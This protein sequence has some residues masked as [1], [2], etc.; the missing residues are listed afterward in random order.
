MNGQVASVPTHRLRGSLPKRRLVTAGLAVIFLLLLC[1]LL[2]LLSYI[3]FALNYPF[4]L[5][6]GEG[7]V[8]QQARNIW[9]GEGYGPLQIFPAIVYHY[10]PVY[11]LTF[12]GLAALT[13]LDEMIA[14][15]LVSI[16][17]SALTAVV[18]GMLTSATIGNAETVRTR[19]LCGAFAGL[20]FLSCVPVRMWTPLMRVDMLSVL[21][22]AA[23]LWFVLRALSRPHYIY[24]ASAMFVLGLFVKQI[25]VAPPAA[26]FLV[27]LFTHRLL[28]VRGLAAAL[29]MG[30]S[31]LAV[32]QWLNGSEFLRHIVGYNVNR[33]ALNLLWEILLPQLAIHVAAIGLAVVG[34]MAA[35][36]HVRHI[37]HDAGAMA[38]ARR[39]VA[40]DPR[41]T[42]TLILIAFL[43]LK[44]VLL[45]AMAKSG[46]NY[47]YMVDWF[48]GI[49]IF[50]GVAIAPY[51]AIAL[52]GAMSTPRSLLVKLLFLALPG[53]LIAM[54]AL[55]DGQPATASIG[56]R[57]RQKQPIVDMIAASDRPVISDDMTFPIRAGRKVQ[58]E[59]AITA[60]L[61]AK[62]VYD[63]DGFARLVRAHCFGFFAIDGILG[64]GV[65]LSR[66]QPVVIA[67]I[68]DAYP[69]TRDVGKYTLHFPAAPA[70]PALCASVR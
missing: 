38:V 31:G 19:I 12:E 67:A 47:N 60:E 9:A 26:A 18:V 45:A 66:Y 36:S 32:E 64:Q 70:D 14:G 4:Q 15:R 16:A 24:V 51:V 10:P 68:R 8:W 28:A 7:I 52:G 63:Q 21:F 34:G 59:S 61:G 11:H 48:S 23:G 56:E 53:Q 17:S 39:R 58:W 37:I 29:V 35:W 13:G 25:S 55:Y 41:A 54:F 20:L 42:L 62:G 2:S 6:Y 44:T 40:D 27:L 1:H 3:G 5:D 43:G 22:G 57:L 69:H 50:A 65:S 49:A 30:L 33:F 46:A